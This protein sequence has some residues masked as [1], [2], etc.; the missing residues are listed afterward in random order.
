[1]TCGPKEEGWFAPEVTVNDVGQVDDPKDPWRSPVEDPQGQPPPPPRAPSLPG[2][3]QQAMSPHTP[4]CLMKD[5]HPDNLRLHPYREKAQ[6]TEDEDFSLSGLLQRKWRASLV[7]LA[8][9]DLG[10]VPLKEQNT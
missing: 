7:L 9:H 1:M 3:H 8:G 4:D 6:W 10:T 2:P 5:P